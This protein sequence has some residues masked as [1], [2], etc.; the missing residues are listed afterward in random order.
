MASAMDSGGSGRFNP[1]SNEEMSR[2]CSSFVRKNMEKNT[3]WSMKVYDEWREQRNSID[4]S[5]QCPDDLLK[6]PDINS[7]NY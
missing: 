6:R 1:I 2:I 5:N 7:L 4:T 3:S